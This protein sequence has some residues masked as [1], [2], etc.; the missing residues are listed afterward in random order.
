[1]E[2]CFD[3]CENLTEAPVIPSNVT[4]MKWCFQDCK[5]LTKAP[6]IPQGVTDIYS[7]FQGCTRLTQVPNIPSSVTGMGQCFKYCAALTDGPDIPSNVRDMYQCFESCTNLRGVKLMCNYDDQYTYF[8]DVFKDCSKLQDD[9]I[10]VPS[11][12]LTDYQ[13]HADKMGTKR[14]KF[15]AL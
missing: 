8:K 3:G 12:S 15:S 4:N 9:G 1:M 2:H 6:V 10:K 13:D 11:D 14:D 5:A 7:C